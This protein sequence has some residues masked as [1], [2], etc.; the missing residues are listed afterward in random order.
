MITYLLIGG[1][2]GCALYGS[3]NLYDKQQTL[4][5]VLTGAIVGCSV[6]FL[7]PLVA[8]LALIA[9]SNDIFGK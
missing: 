5:S 8:L 2:V 1:F 7:W 4:T 9:F 6:V 3:E